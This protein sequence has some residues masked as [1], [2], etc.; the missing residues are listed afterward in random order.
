MSYLRSILK[1]FYAKD[2]NVTIAPRSCYP[3]FAIIH[4]VSIGSSFPTFTILLSKWICRGLN[5]HGHHVIDDSKFTPPISKARSILFHIF[6][7]YFIFSLAFFPILV[8]HPI[9]IFHQS[10]VHHFTNLY[11]S[12]WQLLYPDVH[13]LFIDKN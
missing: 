2:F 13:F 4:P 12:F 6:H 1:H 7:K 11:L 3:I 10:Y 8:L 9:R 5:C